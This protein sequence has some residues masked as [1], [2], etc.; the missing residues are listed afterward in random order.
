MSAHARIGCCKRRRPHHSA[1]LVP[2]LAAYTP[3]RR[4]IGKW[5]FWNWLLSHKTERYNLL[6]ASRARFPKRSGFMEFLEWNFWTA[7]VSRRG[8]ISVVHLAARDFALHHIVST[9]LFYYFYPSAPTHTHEFRKFQ[10]C[11][12]KNSIK[13]GRLSKPY[14]LARIPLST[15]GSVSH[16]HWHCG[17]DASKDDFLVT[18][19]NASGRP[20]GPKS[21]RRLCE[22]GY[23]RMM[24]C[25]FRSC[26]CNPSRWPTSHAATDHPACSRTKAVSRTR[27]ASIGRGHRQHGYSR[28]H[29]QRL[30]MYHGLR[31]SSYHFRE[32]LCSRQRMQ[33]VSITASCIAEAYACQ[34]ASLRAGGGPARD[35]R[36]N[37]LP[38]EM[39]SGS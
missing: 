38:A 37:A 33:R 4:S 23:V 14:V 18:I 32:A 34:Y 27:T 2:Q 25:T 28:A 26:S 12:S 13:Y 1:S 15:E 11:L 19:R 29:G 21:Q 20:G 10:K 24:S 36:P 3:S 7:C 35:C 9:W 31:M 5:N 17:C 6:G 8:V 22:R 39:H 16:M 30:R